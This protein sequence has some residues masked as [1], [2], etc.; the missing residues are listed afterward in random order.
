LSD[1]RLVAET[2]RAV[3]SKL[4][5]LLTFVKIG[6]CGFGGVGPWARR[7]IVEDRRWVS[8]REYAEILGLCQILPGPNVGNIAVCIGDRFHGSL[9]S[10][11][12]VAGLLSGPL[13]I[14]LCLAMLYDRAGQIPAVHAAIGGIASAAAGLFIGTAL[15]IAQ[16]LQLNAFALAVL[17]CS[18]VAA[19]LLRWPLMAVVAVLAPISIIAA[20]RAQA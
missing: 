14:L 16:R 12:A 10:A 2:D 7:I 11:L 1:A 3:P 19:G 9:G 6:L 18:F 5:V 4:G 8:E 20:W 13:T 17:A 15:R